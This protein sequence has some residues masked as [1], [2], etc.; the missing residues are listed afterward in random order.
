[1]T[2]IPGK[3]FSPQYPKLLNGPLNLI[4]LQNVSVTIQIQ[5]QKLLHGP[6]NYIIENFFQ[7]IDFTINSHEK[8]ASGRFPFGLLV[9][10]LCL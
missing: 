3:S 4:F 7:H 2:R 6:L 10:I 9:K 5:Y 1:M 8:A